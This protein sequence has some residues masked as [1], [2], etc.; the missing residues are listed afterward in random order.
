MGKIISFELKKYMSHMGTYVLLIFMTILLV[1]SLFVYKPDARPASTLSLPGDSVSEMYESF[2][3]SDSI[4][5][6]YDAIVEDIGTQASTYVVKSNLYNNFNNPETINNL[7]DA[8]DNLCIE[9]YNTDDATME[10]YN[11]LVYGIN[12]AL[13]D[14]QEALN[15]GLEYS[16]E[17]LEY[18]VLTTESN[19]AKLNTV[20]TNITLNFTSPSNHKE[21]GKNYYN[22]YRDTLRNCLESL[23]YPKLNSIGTK[24]YLGG[25][26]Y[27]VTKSRL[28]EISEKME[29]EHQKVVENPELEY[30]KEIKSNLNIS[31]NRYVSVIKIYETAFKADI[32]VNALQCVSSNT[33]RQNLL[34]YSNVVMYNKAE[35]VTEYEYY[36]THH[37]N[38]EDYANCFSVTH[39]SNFH[40]NAYD[41]T[42][43]VISIFAVVIIV[44]SLY[45]ASNTISGEINK[46]TMRLTALRP[47]KRGYI[48]FGKYLSIII[49]STIMLL[50][51]SLI[52]FAVG[53]FTYGVESA[54]MLM[55]INGS[56]ILV[57]HPM[58]MLVLFILSILIQIIVYSAIATLLSSFIKS[59]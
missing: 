47:V 41:Y 44:F 53:A 34:G 11:Q 43:F 24:Y 10:A 17:G 38:P 30:S 27:T 50:T 59:D 25:G 18:Y 6:S 23:V 2:V 13:I 52:T 8:F 45:M 36:L 33:D 58:A 54:N 56:N 48:F 28:I 29:N 55:I 20:L 4:K 16:K 32:C 46:N 14:L 26:Y 1:A 40:T 49:I 3:A 57:A 51:T 22:V 15:Q 42:Y 7:F 31:F 21:A 5:D 35:L 19:Y 12:S 9:Y 39:T 37:S